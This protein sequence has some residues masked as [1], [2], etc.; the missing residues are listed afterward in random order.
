M[1]DNINDIFENKESELDLSYTHTNKILE[2]WPEKIQST[3][4]IIWNLD[5][6]DLWWKKNVCI[7]KSKTKNFDSA[8][9]DKRLKNIDLSIKPSFLKILKKSIK[10][11]TT[12]TWIPIS[13][14]KER[15]Y[16]TKGFF[17]NMLIFFVFL[18]LFLVIDKFL[19]ED[20]IN[21]WYE[22][23]LSIKENSWNIDF[24]E[25]NINDARLDF[26][27]WNILFKPFLL[28]PNNTIESW[29]FVLQ[30]WSNLTRLLDEWI[31]TYIAT[32]EFIDSKWWINAIELT[33][34]LVNLRE[35]FWNITR[36]LYETILSYEKVWWLGDEEINN[37][38]EF[39]KNKLKN[40][41]KI[42]DILNRDF[43]VFL[44]LLAH[45]W[46]RKYL[47]LFQNNDEIR[48]TWW[49]IWSLATITLN[50]WKVTDFIKDDVYAYEW[51]INKIYTDKNPSPEWLNKIT[52]T[53]WLRD[54]N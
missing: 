31:Q 28:I 3:N 15:V 43:D 47:I 52:E 38:L 21:S 11:R 40:W 26:I 14:F 18:W 29:Y 37:K 1:T 51:E 48:P 22:K 19:V 33:N 5:N 13:V 50:N 8:M 23:I 49:F 6:I 46:E 34:L 36:K 44:N 20:R 27:I 45:K 35:D 17:K 12:I 7:Q 53:F 30:W 16:F 39:A 32:K 4:D 9:C 54:A 25:K 42:L 10:W 2:A 41:Y 24:V